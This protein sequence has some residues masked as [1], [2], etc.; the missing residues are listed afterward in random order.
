MQ[1]RRF[2]K[3]L[4]LFAMAMGLAFVSCNQ[5]AE[6]EGDGSGGSSSGTTR[7]VENEWTDGKISKEGQIKKY[8]ISVTKGTRYF[9]YMNNTSAGDGT[10]TA[11][12]GLKISHSDGTTISSNYNNVVNCWSA[13]FTFVASSD[14][15]VT[16][17]MAAYYSYTWERG[18]GTYAIKYTSRQEYDVLSEGVWKDDNII[19]YGQTNKYQIT[20]TAGIRYFIYMNNVSAGDGTKTA[21]TGLKIFYN[22]GTIISSNYNDVVNCWSAPFTFV[23]SKSG[24]ITITAASYYNYTWERGGGS[25]AIKYTT[26]PEYD[27]LF[28]NIWKNDSIIAYGQTNKYSISVIA[29]KKY[30]IQ[31]NDATN[32]DGTKSANRI[33]IKIVYSQDS[34]STNPT[35]Q[36]SYIYN[37]WSS[38]YQFT[39]PDTGTIIITVASY[40]NYT[41]E[42]GGGTYAIKYTIGDSN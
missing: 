18:V 20:V 15:T 6:D 30:N 23:A 38:P 5:G 32:G 13:P 26:R 1:M 25:Y 42:R 17:T 2:G 41:W 35:I 11:Y 7:L 3:S 22:N 28:E 4:V 9:I 34:N 19:A 36:G 21:Y 12:T 27:S 8:T 16:M 14:G 31:L 39:A 29:G 10:K 24:T 33:G 37:L 40:Y